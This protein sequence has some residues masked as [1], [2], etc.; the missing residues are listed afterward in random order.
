MNDYDQKVAKIEMY[1]QPI[2]EG[3]GVWLEKSGLTKKTVKRHCE[4]IDFFAEYLIYYEPLSSLDEAD[5][6]DVYMFLMNWYPRKAMWASEAHTKSYMATFRKFFVYL[7]ECK[8]IEQS[9]VD[10]VKG[11]LKE[12]KESFLE[13]VAFEDDDY[14]W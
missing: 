7:N 10:E 5:N 13:A 12:N 6:S 11:T 3:F 8:Q 4:N 2:L 14:E 9:V 1:N